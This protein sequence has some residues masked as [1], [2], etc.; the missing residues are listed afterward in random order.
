M[1]NHPD[2][3]PMFVIDDDPQV[4]WPVTV[5][6]PSSGGLFNEYRFTATMRVLSPRE[7][8]DL[9]K[10]IE[11][12]TKAAN[13]KLPGS[14]IVERNLPI[15]QRLITGWQD[16]NDRA[17]NTVPFTPEKLAEQVTGKY[18]LA[19]GAGLWKAISEIRFGFRLDD[20][21]Q[22]PGARLGN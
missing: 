6:L 13:S 18:G 19:L 10:D 7:Y 21:T 12:T 22:Q 15:F 1:E 8:E 9:F 4:D 3:K 20:G 5:K 14:K 17:G 16:V 11:D 2:K